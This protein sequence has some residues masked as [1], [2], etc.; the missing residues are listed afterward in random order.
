MENKYYARF[1]LKN[2]RLRC[3]VDDGVKEVNLKIKS[4]IEF[5]KKSDKENYPMRMKHGKILLLGDKDNITF[6]IDPNIFISDYKFLA[7]KTYKKLKKTS[8]EYMKAKYNNKEVKKTLVRGALIGASPLAA[9]FLAVSL[10]KP[11]ETSIAKEPLAIESI[12]DNKNDKVYINAKS[13]ESDNYLSNIDNLFDEE[14]QEVS[15]DD[16]IEESYDDEEYLIEELEPLETHYSNIELNVEDRSQEDY[17]IAI[18]EKYADE[19]LRAQYRWGIDARIL[20]AIL[21]QESNDQKVNLMQIEHDA[22]ADEIMK[23]YNFEEERYMNVVFTDNPSQYYGK[24][25][26]TISK[27][28][29]KNPITQLGAAAIIMN[30][31]N[32]NDYNSILNPSAMIDQYNKGLTYFT[33]ILDYT[34]G[35]REEILGNPNDI[36][37][38]A[39]ENAI[40]V[41]DPEYVNNTMRYVDQSDGPLIIYTFKKDEN[42]NKYP[43]R[44]QYSITKTL[45]NTRKL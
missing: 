28:E 32:L 25:D 33:K 14:M 11:K 27:E 3:V 18:R 1:Y 20:L 35:S 45:S 36:S 22:I 9:I 41:G 5:L 34:P 44:V 31:N 17:A 16:T 12:Q 8:K 37:F 6:E 30:Y 23:V 42:G 40:D 21:T 7:R 2:N 19:A 13:I 39:Y 10:N 38:M 26:M 24:V 4:A 15:Y 29:L 43:V